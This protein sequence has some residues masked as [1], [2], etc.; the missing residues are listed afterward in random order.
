MLNFL[1]EKLIGT[2][3]FEEIV[4]DIPEN[5]K[6]TCITDNVEILDHTS[7]FKIPKYLET[8]NSI[9]ILVYF[10]WNFYFNKCNDFQP[11]SCSS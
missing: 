3:I 4:E 5:D 9:L 7:L 6:M 11:S 1:G 8:V 10:L 2:E